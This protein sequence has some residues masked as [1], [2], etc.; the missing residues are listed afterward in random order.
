MTKDRATIVNLQEAMGNPC[1]LA[2]A[3]LFF[4]FFRD[5]F[6]LTVA[7]HR[8]LRCGTFLARTRAE[9]SCTFLVEWGIL[10]RDG[11]IS[12]GKNL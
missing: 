12:C 11:N 7:E 3:K 9:A 8:L 6:R 1:F 2:G 4:C 10:R 5:C